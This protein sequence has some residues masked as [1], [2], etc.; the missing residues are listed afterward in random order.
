MSFNFLL[1][2]HFA[3]SWDSV[4]FIL[5]SFLVS[6]PFTS[7]ASLNICSV[8]YCFYRSLYYSLCS[9]FSLVQFRF[10]RVAL[11]FGSRL[12]LILFSDFFFTYSS[13]CFVIISCPVMQLLFVRVLIPFN[14]LLAFNS[15]PW[16]RFAFSSFRF[17]LFCGWINF[18]SCNF[19]SSEFN[20]LKK[21][22][23]KKTSVFNST[24][25]FFFFL[26]TLS[27][28][29]F[30][31]LWLFSFAFIHLT[32]HNNQEGNI[33]RHQDWPWMQTEPTK[34]GHQREGF[35]SRTFTLLPGSVSILISVIISGVQL[36]YFGRQCVISFLY[37]I[38]CL[39]PSVVTNSSCSRLL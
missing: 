27:T 33:R 15:L 6:L 18:P 8:I 29:Y 1:S 9:L 12:S 28:I 16:H 17:H 36:C 25:A 5:D 37:V 10:I 38:S 35:G 34:I 11:L 26:F 22:D 24:L 21:K 30:Y 7:S 19:L 23:R 32:V 39:S 13:L 31:S 14:Y 20:C 2:R 3:L 4:F